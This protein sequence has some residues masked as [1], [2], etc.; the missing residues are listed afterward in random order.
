MVEWKIGTESVRP[1]RFVGALRA[2]L[3]RFV[4]TT[5]FLII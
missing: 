2:A 4:A 1:A 3:R 5:G